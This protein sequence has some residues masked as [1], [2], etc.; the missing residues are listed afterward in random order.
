MSYLKITEQER[1]EILE[2]YQQ[3]QIPKQTSSG[4]A[5][6]D[7]GGSQSGSGSIYEKIT[8]SELI[9]LLRQGKNYTTKLGKFGD[10]LLFPELSVYIEL[11]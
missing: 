1:K 3:P 2:Q 11:K 10:Q 9:P 6:S 5:M 4:V 8:G 7:P